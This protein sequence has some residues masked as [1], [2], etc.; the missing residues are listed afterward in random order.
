MVIIDDDGLRIQTMDTILKQNLF[1]SN[2]ENLCPCLLPAN[3][4]G[5]LHTSAAVQQQARAPTHVPVQ[6]DSM[7]SSFFRAMA[8]QVDRTSKRNMTATRA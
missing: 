6:P 2:F 1:N 7:D 3:S 5:M 4:C 8:S